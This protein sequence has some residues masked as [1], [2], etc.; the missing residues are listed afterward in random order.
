MY[1]SIKILFSI[2]LA[3]S[4][5][6]PL[7]TSA[8]GIESSGDRVTVT[9]AKFELSGQ[10]GEKITQTLR[11]TNEDS[12]DSLFVISVFGLSVV[13]ENGDVELGEAYAYPNL[14][15]SW[16][17]FDQNG[18]RFKPKETKTVNF[19]IT[20]PD[21]AEPGGK[22]ASIV[23]GMDRVNR[24]A[25]DS[26]AMAKVVSLLM[27]SVAGDIRDNATIESF[28]ITPDIGNNVEFSARVY[29]KGNNHIKPHGQII[30]TNLFGQKVATISFAGENVL[31][32]A[33]RKMTEIWPNDRIRFGRYTAT[34]AT[35]YGYKDNLNL[36]ITQTF[37]YVP[38]V[39]LVLLL[40]LIAI[41]LWFLVILLI[42]KRLQVH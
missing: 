41:A 13:N 6:A 32:G 27:L 15:S 7:R 30:I 25:G 1:Q 2:L 38:P 29:N 24:E 4:V 34:L 18:F 37:W 16:V 40:F 9:P 10:P 31:P 22:Y 20:I 19:T 12:V 23:M 39:I 11:V 5:F 26:A 14:F 42:R 28:S 36:S 3:L 33:I 8:E 21:N 17:K 35:T